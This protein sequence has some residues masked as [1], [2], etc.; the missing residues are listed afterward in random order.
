MPLIKASVQIVE[1][2]YIP[3]TQ[4][5]KIVLENR[6]SSDLL[7]E[8][9][10]PYNFYSSSPVFEIPAEGS[11]TLQVKTLEVMDSIDLSLRALGAYTAPKQHPVVS[12]EV[13]VDSN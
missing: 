11:Y 9:V 12:W 4:I 7:F 1:A 6:S 3:D 2:S 13:P 8:N 5:L 10:M